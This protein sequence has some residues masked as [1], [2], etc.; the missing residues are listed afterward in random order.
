MEFKRHSNGSILDVN[1]MPKPLP[2]LGLSFQ[3]MFSM[4]GST[5]IVPLLVG[6][7]PSIALFASGV[8][9]L[10]HI[11]ITKHKIP[12]YMGSSFAFVTP[13]ISLMNTTGYPGIAQGVIAVG[14]VY[15]L[16]A[17]LIWLIGSD[18]LD[19]LLP[20]VV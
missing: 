5:V 3:H 18:W 14:L 20:P 4:F 9:T 15:L 17:S 2:W 6:L 13:M 16:V 1:E 8:G 7:S 19:K 12:M 10:L 11:L